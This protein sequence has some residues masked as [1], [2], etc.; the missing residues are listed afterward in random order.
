MCYRKVLWV[1]VTPSTHWIDVVAGRVS[2]MSMCVADN[3]EEGCLGWFCLGVQDYYLNHYSSCRALLGASLDTRLC[4]V[5]CC[6][7][8]WDRPLSAPGGSGKC[9]VCWTAEVISMA[10]SW[11]QPCLSSAS[12]QL[13]YNRSCMSWSC[14]VCWKGN[15]G[16]S[17]SSAALFW[18]FLWLD[19]TTENDSQNTTNQD[20]ASTPLSGSH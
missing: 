4:F 19:I 7:C 6:L 10:W 20:V 17:P 9:W 16:A 11:Q 12:H 2:R 5:G 18:F 14:P 1:R 8:C 15:Y 3:R 13:P